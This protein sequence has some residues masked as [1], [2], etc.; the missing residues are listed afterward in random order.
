MRRTNAGLALTGSLLLL[1]TGVAR[2]DCAAEFADINRVS[3]M[4]GSYEIA[5]TISITPPKTMDQSGQTAQSMHVMQVLPPLSF[6]VRTRS[7][8]I[9]VIG[10][11]RGWIN[12]GGPW[13][14][15]SKEK[16][17]DLLEEAPFSGYFVTKDQRDL[18]CQGVQNV[19]GKSYLTFVYAAV[20]N[21]RTKSPQTTQ[22]TAYF[23]PAT[24]LPVG[25]QT[26]V[27]ILGARI[28]AEMIYKFD[29]SIRIEPPSP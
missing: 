11:D 1:G 3:A 14:E 13:V 17:A 19:D 22:I 6:R 20:V 10:D 24:R 7:A 8:E 18:A 27:E 5:T 26:L 21:V 4:A 15:V 9:V 29:P 12:G 2:A 28:Q 16:L 23:D 25:G